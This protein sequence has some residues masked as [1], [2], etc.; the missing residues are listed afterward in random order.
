MKKSVKKFSNRATYSA[1]VLVLVA[2][3]AVSTFAAP[4]PGHDASA[5]SGVCKNFGGEWVDCP[6]SSSVEGLYIK[7]STG[8]L[9]W[10]TSGPNAC[11]ALVQNCIKDLTKTFSYE[12]CDD[13]PAVLASACDDYCKDVV[14][15]EGDATPFFCGTVTDAKFQSGSYNSCYSG[16]ISCDCSTDGSI[17][18]TKEVL[19]NPSGEFCAGA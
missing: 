12:D 14:A 2:L 16:Y 4:N 18:H 5:I 19:Y 1:I 11:Q 13:P 7:E 10:P 6:P 3:V 8:Q 9:C 17:T 15:C